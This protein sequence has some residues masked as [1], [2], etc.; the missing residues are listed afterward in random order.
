MRK[1]NKLI[2]ISFSIV[3]ILSIGMVYR[4]SNRLVQFKS[5][6]EEKNVFLASNVQAETYYRVIVGS[7]KNRTNAENRVKELK[8]LG[9]DSFI[10]TFSKNES[11]IDKS[12]NK[13]YYAVVAGSFSKRENADI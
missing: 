3:F 7:F 12:T 10:D 4:D 5:R 8:S 2:L 1:V 9:Y 11:N 13:I 6:L